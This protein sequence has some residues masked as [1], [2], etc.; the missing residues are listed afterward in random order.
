MLLTIVDSICCENPRCKEFARVV[1][2]CRG[3]RSYYCPVCG[4][5]SYA[6]PVDASLANEHDRFKEY[7]LQVIQ[8]ERSEDPRP[9]R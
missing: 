4:G 3:V 5:V 9:I 1:P 6:R 2:V 7:L 8:R